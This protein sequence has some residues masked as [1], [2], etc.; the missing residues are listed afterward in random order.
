MRDVALWIAAD[1]FE[2]LE[3]DTVSDGLFE[4]G[5]EIEASFAAACEGYLAPPN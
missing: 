5:D 1:D 2:A 4:R 3:N